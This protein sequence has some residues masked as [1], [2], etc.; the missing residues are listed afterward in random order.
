MFYPVDADGT[1]YSRTFDLNFTG[2]PRPLCHHTEWPTK[3]Y[4]GKADLVYANP[5]CVPLDWRPL[6]VGLSGKAALKRL[7]GK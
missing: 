1:D 7:N 6:G 4:I 2:I 3:D 5:P